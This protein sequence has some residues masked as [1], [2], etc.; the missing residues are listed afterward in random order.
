[1]PY[2]LEQLEKFFQRHLDKYGPRTTAD[3]DVT[4][5]H[6]LKWRGDIDECNLQ[7][8]ADKIKSK[9]LQDKQIIESK[10]TKYQL[11]LK[12]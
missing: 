10:S 11:G 12:V 1:M 9:L 8:I 7:D 4:V 2:T 3:I 5:Q 6:V